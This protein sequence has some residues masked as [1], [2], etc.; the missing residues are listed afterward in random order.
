MLRATLRFWLEAPSRYSKT[1]QIKQN[2]A[3]SNVL[4]RTILHVLPHSGTFLP[5]HLRQIYA[6]DY[7]RWVQYQNEGIDSAPKYVYTECE[8][9]KVL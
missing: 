3:L 8:N 5:H 9:P 4:Y 1:Q 6:K 2:Q 7:A